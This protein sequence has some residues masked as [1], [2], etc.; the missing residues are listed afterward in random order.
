MENILD[1]RHLLQKGIM[2][3]R[4]NENTIKFWYDKWI[5]ESSLVVHIER[6]PLSYH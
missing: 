2:W 1:H 4:R 5:E 3:T 6:D